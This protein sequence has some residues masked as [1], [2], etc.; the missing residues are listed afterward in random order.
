[1]KESRI[2]K[3]PEILR[4]SASHRKRKKPCKEKRKCWGAF[5]GKSG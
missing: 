4:S 3:H 1:M 5:A 2:K